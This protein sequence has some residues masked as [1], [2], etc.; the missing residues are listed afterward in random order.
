MIH[1][2]V[3]YAAVHRQ[4][5]IKLTVEES[6]TVA[7]A[8]QRSGVLNQFPEIEIG[9]AAV[10][11]HSRR[12]ALDSLLQNNDRVEIYRPLQIDPKQA[13]LVKAKANNINGR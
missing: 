5:E 12:V 8:I 4:I 11:I 6:C 13:R 3:A 1:I 9:R 7:L 10:G 2:T